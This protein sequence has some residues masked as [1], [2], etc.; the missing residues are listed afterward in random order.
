MLECF[1][2]LIGSKTCG[3]TNYDLYI[4]DL[5]ISVKK[6]AGIANGAQ[7]TGKDYL[8]TKVKTSLDLVIADV[9]ENI[10]PVVKATKL[11][12]YSTNYNEYKP[13]WRGLNI[14]V[15]CNL[16]RLYIDF[17]MFK[18]NDTVS[19]KQL[20]ITDGSNVYLF[21]FNAIAGMVVTIP[22]NQKF[23]N[24][25]VKIEVDNTDVRTA[26]NNFYNHD[27]TCSLNGQTYGISVVGHFKCDDSLLICQLN[28]IQNFKNAVLYQT[29]VLI[30]EDL[31]YSTQMNEVVITKSDNLKELADS[32]QSRNEKFILMAKKSFDKL[33][34]QSCCYDCNETTIVNFIS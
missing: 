5:N 16:S 6:L 23:N 3:D 15:S 29:A 20:R 24:S 32:Y 11:V 30:L 1:N 27:C 13:E 25:N 34:K 7:I 4:E 14:A 17:V 19:N 31:I 28:T 33:I 8:A 18:C 22:I 26:Q 12:K 21:T 10:E 2:N 9:A